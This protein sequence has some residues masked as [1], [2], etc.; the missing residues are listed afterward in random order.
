MGR[1]T[2]EDSRIF[3]PLGTYELMWSQAAQAF[4]PLGVV[5]SQQKGLQV[6]IELRGGRVVV[7]LPGR[8]FE[9]AV[10]ALDLPV[11]P[12]VGRFGEAMLYAVFPTATV[13]TVAA[14]QEL[15]RL[16]RELP[17][18]VCRYRMH[19]IGQLLQHAPQK[20]GGYHPFGLRIQLGEGH[21]AGAVNGDKE[22][23]AAFFGMHLGEI[24]R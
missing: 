6:L 19:F 12:G 21:L 10:D 24:D 9:G 13:K 3:L 20:I 22:V 5:V 14:W 4:E 15:V 11:G 7:P 2:S 23:L 8:L 18:I 16:G 17:P 1:V